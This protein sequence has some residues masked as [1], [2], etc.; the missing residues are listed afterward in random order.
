MFHT[1]STKKSHLYLRQKQKRGGKIKNEITTTE[2]YFSTVA[3]GR[4]G[5]DRPQGLYAASRSLL[6]VTLKGIR[7]TAAPPVLDRMDVRYKRTEMKKHT[8]L[9]Q[10]TDKGKNFS[11]FCYH[12]LFFLHV[13]FLSLFSVEKGCEK[14]ETGQWPSINH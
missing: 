6:S 4:Q 9:R 5:T 10:P 12:Y 13:S 3:F 14:V 2:A 1:S 8:T 7:G 11:P